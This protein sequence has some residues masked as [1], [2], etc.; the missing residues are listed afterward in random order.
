MT[1][2]ATDTHPEINWEDTK[3]ELLESDIDEREERYVAIGYDKEG[4]CYVGIAIYV[5]DELDEIK[6]IEPK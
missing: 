1:T 6:D 3:F 2:A 5:H 4:K